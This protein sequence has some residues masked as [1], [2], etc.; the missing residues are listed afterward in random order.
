MILQPANPAS[1]RLPINEVRGDR[2]DETPFKDR[3]TKLGLTSTFTK[4]NDS[5]EGQ[6][7]ATD[8]ITKINKPILKLNT[9]LGNA[10]A[11]FSNADFVKPRLQDINKIRNKLL[12]DFINNPEIEDNFNKEFLNVDEALELTGLELLRFADND[13][14][15]KIGR[16]STS[17]FNTV[18]LLPLLEKQTQNLAEKKLIKLCKKLQTICIEKLKTVFENTLT[19]Q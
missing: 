15:T 11:D 5:I 13:L 3:A 8:Y 1:F 18:N 12:K 14:V 2:N 6:P 17:F 7:F 4:M 19:L 9:V 16:V 10:D